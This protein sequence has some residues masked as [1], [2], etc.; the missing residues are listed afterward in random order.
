[1]NH[2]TNIIDFHKDFVARMHRDFFQ[3]QMGRGLIKWFHLSGETWLSIKEE[4]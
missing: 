4:L 1:M 3:G 2:H